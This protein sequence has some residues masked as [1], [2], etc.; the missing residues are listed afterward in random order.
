MPHFQNL[1]LKFCKAQDDV[2][3]GS[4]SVRKKIPP[5]PPFFLKRQAFVE[6]LQG[7]STPKAVQE[8][9]VDTLV[10]PTWWQARCR[11]AV[12]NR[13]K[14]WR[15]GCLTLVEA[16]RSQTF[17]EPQRESGLAA[18]LTV[19]HPRFFAD[20]A[21]GG[22]VAA[23]EGYIRR[24]W[25]CSDLTALVRMICLESE[26]TGERRW[27]WEWLINPFRRVLHAWNR[28]SEAGS[29]R[30]IAAHYDLGNDF[31]ELFLDETLMYSCGIFEQPDSTLYSA[32]VEKNDR[33][34]RKLELSPRDHL[35]EIGTGWGGFAIHAAK[36]YGCRI[37]TT[38]IS[39]RQFERAIQ[40]IQDAGLTGQVTVLLEDYRRLNGQ[41]DKLVSIEMLEAVGHQYFDTFFRKCDSLLK[42]DG[43][44]ALQTITLA[45]QKWQDYLREVDFIQKY[46]FPGGCLPSV[47][48]ICDSLTR[49]S[50]LRVFHLEDLS[51]HY[52]LTLRHWRR[53]FLEKLDQVRELGYTEDF[54]R[55][56]EY[57]LCYSEGAFLERAVGDVQLVLRKPLCRLG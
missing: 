5:V 16:G 17:G 19:H 49:S 42:P 26:M 33:L 38:T 14:N 6:T 20:L 30:N 27:G 41:Y 22:N 50:Q 37:T 18:T 52:A 35:L 23:G 46:V 48:A 1:F 11:N 53:R 31:Y 40:R 47:T 44:M 15:S 43:C 32:S 34:C 3:V 29:R 12:L 4:P 51:P 56:W 13:L 2:D 24:D 21:F 39:Q 45:D 57:Y 54:I 28:N 36:N 7:N 55:L 9:G 8:P 10:R 25:T